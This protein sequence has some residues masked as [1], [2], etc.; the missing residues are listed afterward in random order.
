MM[1]KHWKGFN[2]HCFEV[3]RKE[4]V[5]NIEIVVKPLKDKSGVDKII[6]KK[7]PNQKLNTNLEF[8][9]SFD[10]SNFHKLVNE[11]LKVRPNIVAILYF[12]RVREGVIR[13][14]AISTH[15][16]ASFRSTKS[17]GISHFLAD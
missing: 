2:E 8:F 3:F 7:K 1:S 17:D 16:A 11:S 15:L 6:V 10:A 4:Q 9:P 12:V 13:R 5:V 14:L